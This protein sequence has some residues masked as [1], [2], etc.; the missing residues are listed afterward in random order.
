MLQAVDGVRTRAPNLASSGATNY[1]T[2]AKVSGS[3][4]VAAHPSPHCNGTDQ[5][6]FS[7]HMSQPAQRASHAA[8]PEVA[9]GRVELPSP[10]FG[11]PAPVPPVERQ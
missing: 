3:E 9:P 5:E 7:L 11:G 1:T 4:W 6:G 8:A 2:T 10:A